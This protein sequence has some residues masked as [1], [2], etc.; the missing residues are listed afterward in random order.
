MSAP[1]R[2]RLAGAIALCASVLLATSAIGARG[3][4]RAGKAGAHARGHAR[5]C[6]SRR[7]ARS[8]RCRRAARR[9]ASTQPSASASTPAPQTPAA[10]FGPAPAPAQ[11]VL[12]APPSSGSEPAPAPPTPPGVPIVQFIAV[13]YHY[14]LSRAS[15]PAGEVM[16]QFVNHGQDE[17]NLNS[18]SESGEVQADFP[19]SGSGTVSKL[20]VEL[21]PGRYT[22]FCSLPEHE[23]KGM[24]AT[25]TVE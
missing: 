17:H 10:A 21:R 22:F 20:E 5:S 13:E 12:T 23:K 16:L 4:P 11:E 8:R 9:P 6:T 25:L 19:T 1:G 7:R 15:V 14:T 3:Q 18:E 2:R 24:K